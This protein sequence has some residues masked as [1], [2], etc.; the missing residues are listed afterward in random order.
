M[1]MDI[2]NEIAKKVRN[3]PEGWEEHPDRD[4]SPPKSLEVFEY[5]LFICLRDVKKMHF[6]YAHLLAEG[7]TLK[8]RTDPKALVDILLAHEKHSERIKRSRFSYKEA[9]EFLKYLLEKDAPTGLPDKFLLGFQ[10]NRSGLSLTEKNEIAVQCAA[11]I[12]WSMEGANIPTLEAMRT[13]LGT[14]NDPIH[15]LLK[16]SRFNNERTILKWI[17][18]VFPVPSELRK[19]HKHTAKYFENIISIPGIF[20]GRGVNFL[21]LLFALQCLTRFMKI[22]GK[23]QEHII[24]TAPVQLLVGHFQFYLQDYAKEWIHQFYQDNGSIFP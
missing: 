19:D 8:K 21:K 14:K 23:Q 7:K 5:R 12:L 16:L 2:E 4:F 6:G 18:P 9:Y 3:R 1:G 11:Q 15:R 17:R 10:R 13:R 24:L 20:T 22:L